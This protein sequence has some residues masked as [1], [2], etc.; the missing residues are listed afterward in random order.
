MGERLYKYRRLLYQD[1]KI[2]NKVISN[3]HISFCAL[4]LSMWQHPKTKKKKINANINADTIV[5]V[6]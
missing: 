3:G 4:F 2:V 5:S 6:F 1:Q